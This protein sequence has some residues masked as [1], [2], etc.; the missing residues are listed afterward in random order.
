M[1]TKK[2]KTNSILTGI[3]S[4]ISLVFFKWHAVGIDAYIGVPLGLSHRVGRCIN[5]QGT[6][7]HTIYAMLNIRMVRR[8][9]LGSIFG[10]SGT[11]MFTKMFKSAGDLCEVNFLTNP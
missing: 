9:I 3:L 2:E 7:S 5:V 1:S 4:A 8:M 11:E 10:G 6:F